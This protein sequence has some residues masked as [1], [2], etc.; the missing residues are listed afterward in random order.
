MH[1]CGLFL[2]HAR[3]VALASAGKQREEPW[4]AGG[5]HTPAVAGSIPA[6]AI[7]VEELDNTIR[8]NAAGPRRAKGDSGEMEQHS[9]KD[10]IEA[11]KYLA[12][13]EALAKK[14]FGMT[15]A[16]IIPP[17]SA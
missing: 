10:Q 12:G 8:D 13:K 17:G 11:D 3:L 2:W 6:P 1:P 7:M 4:W 15:R 16:K 5:S 14:N 9:P